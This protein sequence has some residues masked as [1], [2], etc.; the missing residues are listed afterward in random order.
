MP[1]FATAPVVAVKGR[2][3]RD[4]RCTAW[5]VES[6]GTIIHR[7]AGAKYTG[8]FRADGRVPDGRWRPDEDSDVRSQ[9]AYDATMTRIKKMNNDGKITRRRLP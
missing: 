5:A 7:G 2:V 8:R 3:V 9:A 4:V 1:S 6:D